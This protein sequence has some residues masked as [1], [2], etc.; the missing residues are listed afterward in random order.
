[1]VT[2]AKPLVMLTQKPKSQLLR[3]IRGCLWRVNKCPNNATFHCVYCTCKANKSTWLPRPANHVIMYPSNSAS[4][5]AKTTTAGAYFMLWQKSANG[6]GKKIALK[7]IQIL[8]ANNLWVCERVLRC[9]AACLELFDKTLC[10]YC[11]ALN[12]LQTSLLLAGCFV[13]VV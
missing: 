9:T 6:G 13:V 12:C 11:K 5:A 3:A 10:N 8:T 7:Q 1:M 2:A 4:T